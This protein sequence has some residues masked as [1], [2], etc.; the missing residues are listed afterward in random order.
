[1]VPETYRHTLNRMQTL[2]LD[3]LSRQGQSVPETHIKQRMQTLQLDTLSRYSQSVLK[4]QRNTLRLDTLGRETIVSSGTVH[5]KM[6]YDLQ[7]TGPVFYQIFRN[8]Q[9]HM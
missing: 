2:Q 4:T 6:T 7:E 8:Q 5:S 9:V 1:M 3:T